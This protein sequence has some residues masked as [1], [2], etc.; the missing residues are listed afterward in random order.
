IVARV[1][2]GVDP[3][4]VGSG[5]TGGTNALRAMGRRRALVVGLLDVAKGA[6][7]ALI[8]IWA[9]ASPEV[10][11]LTGVA[12]VFGAWR[13]IFL[14]FRGG[15]GV[16][17]SVGGML[18]VSVPVVL[19]SLPVFIG[20][21]YVTRY[22]SLGSLL[23]TAFAAIVSVLFVALGWL[24]A[25]WLL[26]SAGGTAIVWLAHSDNIARLRAGT[27]RRLGSARH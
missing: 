24:D 10:G 14:R 12:A 11:A 20:I 25:G 18:A 6:V 15:R 23:G 13:S 4:S 1:T 17:T 8:A 9:G 26:F 7:P 2:G 3:R 5:R 27:E 19:I 16:A 22:V 21:I